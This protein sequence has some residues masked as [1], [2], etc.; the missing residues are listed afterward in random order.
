[1]PLPPP[2][3]AILCAALQ[4]IMTLIDGQSLGLSRI[5]TVTTAAMAVARALASA[6]MARLR[7]DMTA[8]AAAAVSLP[9]LRS[10]VTM[11]AG[12]AARAD[13]D[14][15]SVAA[16]Q[17][18]QATAG[19][20]REWERLACPRYR[21][22]TLRSDGG[23]LS[24]R[25]RAVVAAVARALSTLSS[26]S[27]EPADV[28]RAFADVAYCDG[29]PIGFRGSLAFALPS[30]SPSLDDGTRPVQAT[31]QLSDAAATLRAA[32]RAERVAGAEVDEALRQLHAINGQLLAGNVSKAS[33]TAAARNAALDGD[34]DGFVR[35]RR[36]W[37]DF[38]A[39][40]VR[41]AGEARRT[42]DAVAAAQAREVAAARSLGNAVTDW[43][44][45][46]DEMGVRAAGLVTSAHRACRE[47]ALDIQ[48]A[49]QQQQRP[50]VQQL[51]CA[52]VMDASGAMASPNVPAVAAE[53]AT[54]EDEAI[55][56]GTAR[57]M[58]AWLNRC[59]TGATCPCQMQPGIS[60]VA[61]T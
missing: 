6:D 16:A 38:H 8:V 21:S 26:R 29:D 30:L 56:E 47:A 53:A 39:S 54:N 19:A 24:P 36:R 34:W 51:E 35:S 23:G 37:E 49:L 20:W 46:V 57:T 2:A 7:L 33:A 13:V 40:G 60:S 45:R 61:G 25:I 4:S 14:N 58:L 12:P 28:H 59:C 43:R 15:R 44:Q 27:P 9:R 17:A 48:V 31:K 41:C 52:P 50:P 55:V 10:A 3:A 42:G 18:I 22:D 1:M 11:A 32:R 5:G